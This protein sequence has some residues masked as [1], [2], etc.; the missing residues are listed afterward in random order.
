MGNLKN[1]DGLL[2]SF[3]GEGG[4]AGAGLRVY[5]GT[6]CIYEKV[7]G[8]ANESEKRPFKA[9]TICQ[10]A[11]MTKC[12]A[13][14]AAM[15]LYEKGMFLLTDPVEEYIP[16]FADHKVFV[17]T[18]RGET[19]VRPAS[20]SVTVGDLFDM[21]SGITVDWHWNNPNSE[22][23]SKECDKL[24]AEGRYNLREFAKVC[25]RTPGAFDP[26]EHFFYGQSHDILAALIEILTGLSFGE[27]L[28]RN[29]FNPLGIKDMHFE[30]P[31]DKKDRCSVMYSL[32]NGKRVVGKLPSFLD[33]PSFESA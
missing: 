5:V 18:V 33:F 1:L 19:A 14:T 17:S 6:D 25:G 26:G 30:V 22:A 2:E 23:L 29:I 16:E 21:T 32:N 3:V 10:M 27:Y 15:Q 7:L 11:S 31:D 9:D 24:K 28:K 4:P 12:I 13:V 8:W 20:R